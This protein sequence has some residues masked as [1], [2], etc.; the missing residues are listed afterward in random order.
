MPIYVALNQLYHSGKISV[1]LALKNPRDLAIEN[2]P[3]S[4][5]GPVSD[6]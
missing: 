6:R 1:L 2:R 4:R 5:Y 3:I